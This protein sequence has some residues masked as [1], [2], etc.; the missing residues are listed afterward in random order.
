MTVRGVRRE[1][2][3]TF[4][5]IGRDINAKAA[6]SA[7]DDEIEARGRADTT[8]QRHIDNLNRGLTLDPDYFV[9]DTA[10]APAARE[11]RAH[12]PASALPAGTTHLAMIIQ[13]APATAR[14]EVVNTGTYPFSFASASV[15]NISRHPGSTAD[16]YVEFYDAANGGN[17][18]GEVSGTI[19]LVSEAPS[20]FDPTKANLFDAV[21]AIFH[22]DTN[23]GVTA[24]DANNELD[25]IVEPRENVLRPVER[26]ITTSGSESGVTNLV[27]PA[28]YADYDY[29]ELIVFD[30]GSDVNV[31]DTIRVRTAWLA[32]QTDADAAKIGTLDNDEAG[33]RQWLLWTPSTRTLARGVQSDTSTNMRVRINSARLFDEGKGRSRQ[34][35]ETP[36]GASPVVLPVGTHTLHALAHETDGDV[37]DHYP[38]SMLVSTLSAA[39]RDYTAVTRSP[40]TPQDTDTIRLRATYI[41]ATRTFT[42]SLRGTGAVLDHLIAVGEA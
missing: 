8:L 10:A 16:V 13:G 19:L 22:P 11:I 17:D 9:R 32:A 24:D 15:A 25:V 4:E 14:L 3:P 21:K 34:R 6:Q 1:V 27:L 35:F 37:T 2:N 26:Q 42:Y 23:A 40:S 20:S 7:L 38:W 39:E 36:L 29:L 12:V 33:S 18:L 41:A 30:P 31:T 28:N 5:Q